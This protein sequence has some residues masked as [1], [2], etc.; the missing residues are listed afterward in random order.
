MRGARNDFFS[1]A[2]VA[3]A[4]AVLT[5]LAVV[6]WPI[7]ALGRAAVQNDVL[8][9]L[10]TDQELRDAFVW[11]ATQSG[12]ACA[13]GAFFGLASAYCWARLRYP[14]RTILRG[15]AVAPI[16]IPPIALA[17]GV[18]ALFAPGT[19]ASDF[20]SFL[21]IDPAQ[22]RQ[23]SGAIILTQSL[24]AT[25]AVGWFASVAWASV[26][27]RKVD[28]ARTL[29]AGRLRATRL[30]VW[31]E[32]W[33]AVVAGTGMAFLGATLSYGLVAILSRDGVTSEG[34]TIRLILSDDNRAAGVAVLTAAYALICGLITIQFLRSP[35]LEPRRVRPPHRARGL[36][37]LV[38][39]CAAVPAFVVIS[40]VTAL[41]LRAAGV[42]EGVTAAHVRFL[43]EGAEAEGVRRAALGSLLAA[44]P[45]AAL[46][47]AWGGMAGASLGR[48]RGLGGALRATVLLFPIALSPAAITFGWLLANPTLDSRVVLP[49]MQAA[50][51]LPLV[52]G[53]VARMRPRPRP[54][55]L[56]A[57]R[58]LGARRIR[59]WRTRRGPSYVIAATVGFL[60]TLGLAFAETSAAA[61]ARV[62]GGTLSLR[63]IEL[64]R[65]GA[66]GPAAALAAVILL[67]SVVAFTLGDPI[68]ARL[69]R[70][71][72]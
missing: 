58:T 65:S 33:P 72:R 20:A 5:L 29:G 63:L 21:S 10:R 50:G 16:A 49:L 32:V 66:I 60:I 61:V 40:A 9:V 26:D 54:G 7:A 27:A 69:G 23:G 3:A 12:I 44:L 64:D 28:A 31:P 1:T 38:V 18:K 71:R 34:L 57:A 70:A 52:A 43:V 30:A 17:V 36:D 8:T 56:E 53:T 59:A 51:A 4:G 13:I 24:Y 46:A 47:A 19:P 11:A 35:S 45:A 67:I 37:R 48:M 62:P 42:G 15:L 39:L 22:L 55:M 41:F 14:G 25:A 6:A 68:I 2:P